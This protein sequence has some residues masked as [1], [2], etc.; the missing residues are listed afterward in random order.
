MKTF[1]SG[2]Q[3]RLEIKTARLARQHPPPTTPWYWLC[4]TPPKPPAGAILVN[5]AQ[6]SLNNSYGE[7]LFVRRGYYEDLPFRCVDCGT[8]CVWTAERQHWWYEI[9]QGDRFSTACRCAPC[10]AKERERKTE[11]RRRWQEGLVKKAEQL[12]QAE[13]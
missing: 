13:K 9:A 1:K 10:R 12:A 7:P 4:E 8:D 5:T 11:A 6:L 3:R 2:K